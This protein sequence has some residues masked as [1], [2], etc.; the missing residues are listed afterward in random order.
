MKEK[1]ETKVLFP[2]RK[3][4]IIKLKKY[5]IPDKKNNSKKE[6]YNLRKI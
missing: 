5:I 2:I 4:K 1:Y 6:K 3:Q